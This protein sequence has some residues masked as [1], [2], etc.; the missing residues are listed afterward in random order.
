VLNS[1]GDSIE[2][3]LAKQLLGKQDS[4]LKPTLLPPMA[5][6]AED[7]AALARD[8]QRHGRLDSDELSQQLQANFYGTQAW[9]R[10]GLNRN[11]L[12]TDGVQ[13]FAE[14]GGYA[15]AYWFIDKVAFDYWPLLKTQDFL[16]IRLTVDVDSKATVTVDDGN[17]HVLKTDPIEFTDLQP[18]I[19]K[20]YLTD[21][22]L[23]LPSEY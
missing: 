8:Y 13:F 14:N 22:V 23:L 18:G 7:K 1:D 17:S 6:C 2:V 4:L 15:G 20:F 9:Y 19:W 3:A 16:S 10:H 11:L 12:Y 21:N 5:A